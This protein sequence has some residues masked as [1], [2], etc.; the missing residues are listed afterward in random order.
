MASPLTN[1][2]QSLNFVNGETQRVNVEEWS[3]AIDE[4]LV[5]A[6]RA[7]QNL[8]DIKRSM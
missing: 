6:F 2:A 3:L 5:K 1:Y 7:R 4:A 8:K